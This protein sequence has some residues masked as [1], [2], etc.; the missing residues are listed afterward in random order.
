MLNG[1]CSFVRLFF[2][3]G[4]YCSNE[5]CTVATQ[6]SEGMRELSSCV[7]ARATEAN[8]QCA[9]SAKQAR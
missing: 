2:E 6:H 8:L 1:F 5:Q 9:L 4:P 7:V 3:E